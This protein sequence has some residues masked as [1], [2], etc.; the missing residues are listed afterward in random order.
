MTSPA[1]VVKRPLPGNK[2]AVLGRVASAPA[3]PA[4]APAAAGGGATKAAPLVPYGTGDS[5][6]D[7][8]DS[9]NRAAGPAKGSVTSSAPAPP[10]TSSVGSTAKGLT[11]TI[12]TSAGSGAAVKKPAAVPSPATPARVLGE[13]Q[14]RAPAATSP[15]LVKE[16][17]AVPGSPSLHSEE[18]VTSH[19]SVG[20]TS[21]WLVT[22][23]EG[24]P[25]VPLKA[26]PTPPGWKVTPLPARSPQSDTFD[27]R[28]EV[29][30]SPPPIRRAGSVDSPDGPRH[31][32]S[33]ISRK[34]KTL[35]SRPE[36]RALGED[37]GRPAKR[38]RP[39][40]APADSGAGR[41]VGNSVFFDEQENRAATPADSVANGGAAAANG[42]P[43]VANG[44][45]TAAEAARP[46]G[47]SM[48]LVTPDGLQDCGSGDG[49]ALASAP[50]G[51]IP[52]KEHVVNGEKEH[53]AKAPSDSARH[54]ERQYRRRSRSS[55][56][57]SSEDDRR[58]RPSSAPAA[59]GGGGGGDALAFLTSGAGLSG[60]GR[61]VT[62][63]SG[64]RPGLE[65]ERERDKEERRRREELDEYNDELDAGRVKKVRGHR[66]RPVLD[67]NP[68][69]RLQEDRRREPGGRERDRSPSRHRRDRRD[70]RDRHRHRHQRRD[71]RE[72]VS[73]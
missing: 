53:K 45:A 3:A 16:V 28:S 55:S 21:P 25:A 6:S 10:A 64:E 37:V 52:Q 11:A 44:D 67:H 19:G 29:R 70:D 59:A 34:L 8:S 12:G 1:I 22:E 68:F 63:W 48:P 51:P 65:R 46:P 69:Q 39:A 35:T 18:S 41:K 9:E 43:A 54:Q 33:K 66:E 26:D 50:A 36:K 47:R 24:G 13:R 42:N 71:S 2:S 5:A 58:R 62:T 72:R 20:C 7:D 38:P 56:S 27:P 57:S 15:W 73:R 61:D 17:P 49:A 23:K 14:P 4:P 30:P 31:I 32:L 40:P 60:Y